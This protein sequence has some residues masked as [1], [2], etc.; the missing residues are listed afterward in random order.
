MEIRRFSAFVIILLFIWGCK[1][2]TTVSE[3]VMVSDSVRWETRYRDSIIIKQMNRDSVRIKDSVI[4]SIDSTGAKTTDRWHTFIKYITIN[5]N[6]EIYKEKTDSLAQT[7]RRDSVRV[8]T[9]T[10]EKKGSRWQRAELV[11]LRLLSLVLALALV[12]GY[13]HRKMR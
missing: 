7:A 11:L 9:V 10:M 6:Q 5:D 13:V 8:V 1:T 12:G 2:P 3:S 4:V